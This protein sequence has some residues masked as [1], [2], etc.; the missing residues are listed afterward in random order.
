[1]SRKESEVKKL[2]PVTEI[3]EQKSA[4]KKTDLDFPLEH[5]KLACRELNQKRIDA[6]ELP[7]V[8]ERYG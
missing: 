3:R 4:K 5:A 1:M 8:T 6:G 2:E 7:F